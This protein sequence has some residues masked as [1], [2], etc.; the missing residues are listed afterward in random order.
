MGKKVKQDM[1]GQISLLKLKIEY[2]FYKK[3]KIFLFL[4]IFS[5]NPKASILHQALSIL[6][7]FINLSEWNYV[8]KMNNNNNISDIIK[9]YIILMGNDNPKPQNGQ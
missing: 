5:S 7:M 8:K 2:K 4:L 6:K 3:P 1:R 9:T